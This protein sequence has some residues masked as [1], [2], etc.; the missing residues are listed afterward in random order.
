MGVSLYS[1]LDVVSIR[2]KLS[3]EPDNVNESNTKLGGIVDSLQYSQ[4]TNSTVGMPSIKVS[5]VVS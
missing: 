2:A 3:S 4:P 5:N 1:V